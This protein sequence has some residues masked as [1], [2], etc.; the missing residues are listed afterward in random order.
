MEE[1]DEG[2]PCQ[3]GDARVFVQNEQL[4]G[5]VPGRNLDHNDQ[6]VAFCGGHNHNLVLAGEH[7]GKEAELGSPFGSP[8]HSPHDPHGDSNLEEGEGDSLLFPFGVEDA[9]TS[10]H[11]D[12]PYN[13]WEGNLA[14]LQWHV[15]VEGSHFRCHRCHTLVVSRHTF[16]QTLWLAH[17]VRV[18]DSRRASV[19]TL[20]L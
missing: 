20:D 14:G 3:A 9:D 11:R 4:A 10:N 7:L 2:S 16:H 17:H 18:A 15:A 12:G 6:V 1:V 19:S 13:Q 8:V 5:E